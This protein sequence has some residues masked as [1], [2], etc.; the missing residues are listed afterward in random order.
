ML[1]GVLGVELGDDL[2]LTS[3]DDLLARARAKMHV[4]QTQFATDREERRAKRTQSAK[5]HAQEAR[6]QAEKH[7]LSQLVIPRGLPR[8]ITS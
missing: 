3:P 1:E 4:Q 5:H 2:D 6:Q 7:Q 8:G